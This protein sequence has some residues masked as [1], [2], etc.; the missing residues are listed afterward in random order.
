MDEK[1][2][3]VRWKRNR[4]DCRILVLLTGDEY[5]KIKAIARA[6]G[7]KIPEWVRYVALTPPKGVEIMEEPVV[8]KLLTMLT[9]EVRENTQSI[10]LGNPYGLVPNVRKSSQD[11]IRWLVTVSD[12]PDGVTPEMVKKA[13]AATFDYRAVSNNGFSDP[14]PFSALGA[15]K[16]VR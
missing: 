15:G 8:D 4:R 12:V 16:I 11:L 7:M 10:W 1:P 14:V 13:Y 2:E 5:A 3:K 6:V 9:V